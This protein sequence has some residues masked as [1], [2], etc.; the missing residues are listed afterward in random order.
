VVQSKVTYRANVKRAAEALDAYKLDRGCQ[1]C[2][3]RKH[4]AALHFD[5]VDPAMKLAALG[6]FPDRSKLVTP[7]RLKTYLRHVE[8]YCEVRCANC[9]TERTMREEHWKGRGGPSNPRGWAESK[10][11]PSSTPP[12]ASVVSKG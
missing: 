9:H 8:R 4:P 3:Y 5:H 10:K 12:T 11:L 2:G 6:W 7:A 1:D